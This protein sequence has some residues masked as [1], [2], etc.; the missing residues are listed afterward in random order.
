MMDI[1]YSDGLSAP[2]PPYIKRGPNEEDRDRYQ[3]VFAKK[4]G[5]VAAPTAGLHFTNDILDEIKKKMSQL[6]NLH[7]MLEREHLLLSESEQ[8]ESKKLHKE[9]FEI[10]Q[11]YANKIKVSKANDGRIKGLEQLL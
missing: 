6:V 4:E 8:I 5:A 9:Y 11:S 1:L 3:T 10:D 2:L 7:C